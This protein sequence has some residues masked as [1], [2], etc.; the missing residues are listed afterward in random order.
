MTI[1]RNLLLSLVNKVKNCLIDFV[2]LGHSDVGLLQ[3]MLEHY[4]GITWPSA[5][6]DQSRRKTPG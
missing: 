1:S 4:V 3:T 2:A 6:G 5:S